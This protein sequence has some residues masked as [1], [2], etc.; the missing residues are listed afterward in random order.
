[1]QPELTVLTP[2]YNRAELLPKCYES[3]RAQ[4]CFDFEWLIVDDGSTDNT[5]EIVNSWVSDKS[6]GF[7]TVYVKKPNGGKHTA[8]NYSSKYI[9]GSVVLILDSDDYLTSDA[10]ETVLN[11][12]KD[13]SSDG[14]ICGLSF[15][16]GYDEQTSTAKFGSEIQ[17]SN[18]VDFRVNKKINGYCCEI[19]RT[20]VLKEFPFPEF[21]GEKFLGENYLWVNAGLKYDT[22]YI[23]KI[24][25]ICE[26]LEG[27]L[28]RQGRALRI[29]SPHGGMA[30]SKVELNKRI[31][32]SRR[33]KSAALYS[34]YGFAAGMSVKDIVKTS[35]HPLIVSLLLPLGRFLRSYWG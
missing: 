19:I 1:M 7:E 20:D 27:G 18:H 28:S 14:K 26:Y 23:N 4:T 21:K 2:A 16:K 12:W 22:V 33:I 10:V 25:Y 29:K 9:R 13:Y 34:C 3:L 5:E 24:I 32:L 35:G 31:C 15:L 8:I 11:Y 6:V 30:S 17:R